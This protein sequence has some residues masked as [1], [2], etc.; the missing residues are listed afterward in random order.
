MVLKDV[1]HFTRINKL[2]LHVRCSG[3]IRVSDLFLKFS[4]VDGTG[5]IILLVRD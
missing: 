5:G 3:C 4:A 2:V 1:L